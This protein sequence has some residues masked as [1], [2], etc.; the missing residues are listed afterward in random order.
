MPPYRQAWRRTKGL[1]NF[2]AKNQGFRQQQADDLIYIC[3]F[4]SHIR[5][6]LHID[7]SLKYGDC[8]N[9]YIME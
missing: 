3:N 5:P 9:T 6:A 8:A 1:G 2:K 7:Y 4:P